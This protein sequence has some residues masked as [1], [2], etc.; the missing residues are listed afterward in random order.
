MYGLVDKK[1]LEVMNPVFSIFK[2]SPEILLYY[3][4]NYPLPDESIMKAVD[5]N[6]LW[7]PSPTIVDFNYD[8][9]LKRTLECDLRY[10]INQRLDKF[11]EDDINHQI[12]KKLFENL[13]FQGRWAGFWTELASLLFHVDTISE[14]NALKNVD[15]LIK[16]DSFRVAS[17][18]QTVRTVMYI[19]KRWNQFPFY[20]R[21]KQFVISSKYGSTAT[22]CIVHYCIP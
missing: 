9:E 12:N 19:V 17:D 16:T 14:S 7:N 8:P 22:T 15:F 20:H 1:G 11:D 4:K 5:D 10:L 13:A 18:L 6:L 2:M 3:A 21:K